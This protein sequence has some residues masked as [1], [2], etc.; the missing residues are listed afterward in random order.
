M[1]TFDQR[2]QKVSGNQYNIAGDFNFDSIQN[3][4][5]ISS[6][7]QKLIPEINKAAQNEV[8]NPETAIDVEARV[9]KAVLE[10]QKQEPNPKTILD[11]LD[12]AKGLIE[13]L[14]SA[15]GLVSGLVKAIN[16]VRRLFFL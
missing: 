10:A 9:K 16:M 12:K 1:T 7:L 3:K 6:E 2:N 5:D 14:T 8:I 11:N 15:T 13:S 4:S